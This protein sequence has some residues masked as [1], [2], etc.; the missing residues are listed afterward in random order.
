MSDPIMSGVFSGADRKSGLPLIPGLG[1]GTSK[2]SGFRL[3]VAR[4]RDEER[5]AG[6]PI[7]VHQRAI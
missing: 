2:A 7:R 1:P 3:E 6:A 5:R 4:N